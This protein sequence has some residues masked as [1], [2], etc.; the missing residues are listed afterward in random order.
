LSRRRHFA[1]YRYKCLTPLFP[2]CPTLAGGAPDAFANLLIPEQRAQ[3]VAGLDRTG[4]DAQGL[5]RSTRPWITSFAPGTTQL[6]GD[7][8]KVHGIMAGSTGR[9]GGWHVESPAPGVT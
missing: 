1:D 4:V 7:V 5:T 8:I 2:A 6:V 3:F 9:N